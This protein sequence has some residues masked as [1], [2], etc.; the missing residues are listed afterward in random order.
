MH[1]NKIFLLV[2]DK[3]NLIMLRLLSQSQTNVTNYNRRMVL[4]WTRAKVLDNVII[5][6]FY[7]RSTNSFDLTILKILLASLSEYLELLT[8]LAVCFVPK[9][10]E[11][12][13][14][15]FGKLAS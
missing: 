14:S 7:A 3:S 12:V 10:K 2:K 6:N 15:L 4:V 13:Y 9:G 11:S 8:F 1:N 5:L